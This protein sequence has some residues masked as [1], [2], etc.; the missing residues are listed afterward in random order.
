MNWIITS[1]VLIISSTGL[2]LSLRN[3]EKYHTPLKIKSLAMFASPLLPIFL[4]CY[5]SNISFLIPTEYIIL[6]AFS[7]VWLSWLANIASLKALE[8][9]PNPWYPLIIW[10]SYV[11][12]TTLFS[13]FILWSELSYFKVGVIFMIIIFAA[14]ISVF[15]KSKDTL[16]EKKP[17]VWYTVFTFFAWWNLALVLTYIVQQGISSSIV[18]LYLLLFVSCIIFLEILISWERYQPKCSKEIYNLFLIAVCFTV[19]QQSWVYWYSVSPN[20]GYINAA[21]IAS[22][23]LVTIASSFLFWDHISKISLVWVSGII[24]CL[25]LLF[26]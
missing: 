18:N 17:W 14:L 5:Y 12:Y 25:F 10:K 1:I 11:V 24:V 16:K 20:P 4:Y 23:G 7:A 22:I 26:I 8:N 3:I 6:L 15:W 13:V 21:N 19:F 2:Y 9:S